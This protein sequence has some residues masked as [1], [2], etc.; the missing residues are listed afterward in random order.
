MIDYDQELDD[1]CV[2]IDPR[3]TDIP[4]AGFWRISSIILIQSKDSLRHSLTHSPDHTDR[5]K[6]T[7]LIWK[8]VI[9]FDFK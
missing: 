1:D 9:F 2:G 6:S 4:P 7:S 8:L 3:L 5:P